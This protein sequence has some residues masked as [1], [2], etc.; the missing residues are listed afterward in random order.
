MG[1]MICI[2]GIDCS[3]KTSLAK[4]LSAKLGYSFIEK[5][6]LRYFDMDRDTYT[7]VKAKMKYRIVDDFLDESKDVMFWYQAF[8]NI[9]AYKLRENDN[10]VVDRHLI[11]NA[12]W[13]CNNAGK[14]R[15]NVE[16]LD[17]VISVYGKPDLTIILNVSNSLAEARLYQ[18]VKNMYGT[19]TEGYG[20]TDYER[21]HEKIIHA[22][23]F[24]PFAVK[25]C[26]R[27]NL[28]YLVVET[29]GKTIEDETNQI[30][31]FIQ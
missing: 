26:E 18:R 2:E 4:S 3:G 15:S 20:R 29:D 30:I 12:F 25:L 16:I 31:N 1:R 11:T 27:I 14:F 23:E 22:E 5:P 21:E 17:S 6:M 10:I 7:E 24:V 8:N 13:N 9:I 19:I 28:K